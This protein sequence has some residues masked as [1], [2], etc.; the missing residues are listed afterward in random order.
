MVSRSFDHNWI[1]GSATG[2][3]VSCTADHRYTSLQGETVNLCDYV[4]R[5]IRVVNTA[6]KCGY[7]PQ[8]DNRAERGV[9]DESRPAVPGAGGGVRRSAAMELS[10]VPDRAGRQDGLQFSQRGRAR[11]AR[12]HSAA[13]TD[14]EIAAD[15]EV[16][17]R[18]KTSALRRIPLSVRRPDARL[19]DGRRS[20]PIRASACDLAPAN[21]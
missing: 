16:K 15:A 4:N 3:R 8:F 14:V 10:Q 5:P 18:S 9:G 1:D 19:P 11:C 6:S 2:A 12:N 13:S 17:T 7:T 20:R 21:W